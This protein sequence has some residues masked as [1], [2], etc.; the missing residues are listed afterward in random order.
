MAFDKFKI[1]VSF[2]RSHGYEPVV[3]PGISSALAA[4]MQAGIPLTLRGV[5]DQ[6]VVATGQGK[7]YTI[8]DVP[9]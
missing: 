3:V 6:V 1:Q 5:A 4:P 8:P 2:Y 9:G 7:D